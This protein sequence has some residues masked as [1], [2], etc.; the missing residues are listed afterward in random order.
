M[1]EGKPAAGLDTLPEVAIEEEIERRLQARGQR[2]TAQRRLL[3]DM[4]GRTRRPLSIRQILRQGTSLVQ[5]SLYRNLVVLEDVGIVRR[6]EAAGGS[7]RY[8]LT[9]DLTGH[10]H[11]LICLS[12]GAVED[13]PASTALE[14][15]VRTATSGWATRKGFRVRSHRVDL[16]GLC[17]DCG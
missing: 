11:H 6:L 16:L 7:A 9:E 3:V 14:R 17:R 8:E 10:H 12:C 1:K 2:F 13:L 4:L 15:S 5:S